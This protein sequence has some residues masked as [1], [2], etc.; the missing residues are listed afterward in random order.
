[1]TVKGLKTLVPK[2][3]DYILTLNLSKNNLGNL[4]RH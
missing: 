3:G 4:G 1:M 2:L